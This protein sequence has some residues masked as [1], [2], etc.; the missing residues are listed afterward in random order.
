MTNEVLPLE[1]SGVSASYGGVPAIIDVSLKV[2]SGSITT[3][4][5]ANAAGKSTVI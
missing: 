3:M 5:G 2:K 1:V 4:I